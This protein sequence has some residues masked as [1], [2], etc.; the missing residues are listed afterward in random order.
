MY[1]VLALLYNSIFISPL[2]NYNFRLLNNFIDTA[3]VVAEWLSLQRYCM[4]SRHLRYTSESTVLT[5]EGFQRVFE[6]DICFTWPSRDRTFK[7]FCG[8]NN[9]E[10]RNHVT[11][12]PILV[13][14]RCN[15]VNRS[16]ELNSLLVSAIR[17][18][19]I[20]YF[21]FRN[22]KIITFDSFQLISLLYGLF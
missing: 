8:E 9:R 18:V 4:N 15:F 19:N 21:Y 6:K 5:R 17:R 13:W 12:L 22:W 14:A 16:N 1:F 2:L 10:I 3:K 11:G 7:A 20:F